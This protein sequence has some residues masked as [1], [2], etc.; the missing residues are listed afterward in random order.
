MSNATTTARIR[1][2]QCEN[3]FI[4]NVSMASAGTEYLQALPDKTKKLTVKLRGMGELKIAFVAGDTA[5]NW[6]TIPGGCSFTEEN[7]SLD[8]ATI[9][10]SSNLAAQTAE[11][12]AWT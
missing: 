9:Y 7:L 5:L 2:I 8:G 12:L 3:P 4:F 1:P 6:I 11:L 10:L